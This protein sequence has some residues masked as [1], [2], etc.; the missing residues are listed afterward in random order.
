MQ[1]TD[2]SAMQLLE[3][4]T[5]TLHIAGYM[6]ALDGSHRQS[7]ALAYYHGLSHTEIANQM[8]APLDSV[9]A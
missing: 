6:N 2:P 9:K 4:A 5:Q 7:L 8:G 3:Q 1:G